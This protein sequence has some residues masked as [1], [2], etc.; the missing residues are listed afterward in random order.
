MMKEGR[1]DAVIAIKPLG[2]NIAD[3]LGINVQVSKPILTN[4]VYHA[5]NKEHQ[6][7]AKGLEKSFTGMI[8]DGTMERLLGDYRGMMVPLS[9]PK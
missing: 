5:V 4:L 1:L 7:L 8:Q 3:R 2:I 6:H 9:V